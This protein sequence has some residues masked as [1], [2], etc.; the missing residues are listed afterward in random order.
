MPGQAYDNQTRP[1]ENCTDFRSAV[2]CHGTID[3]T[4]LDAA[5]RKVTAVSRFQL[6][7]KFV[8]SSLP[9]CNTSNT[10]QWDGKACMNS[11]VVSNKAKCHTVHL[12]G[13]IQQQGREDYAD[14]YFNISRIGGKP[15]PMGIRIMPNGDW[16]ARGND[17]G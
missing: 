5:F 6:A 15:R 16:T 12:T 2:F 17:A 7:K 3:Y 4:T 13:C 10:G 9:A 11:L 1:C 14:N 8:S